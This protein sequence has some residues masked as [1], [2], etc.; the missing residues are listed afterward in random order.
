[1]DFSRRDELGVDGADG[2]G[3]AG[4]IDAEV[5]G[6]EIIRRWGRIGSVKVRRVRARPHKNS[7][8]RL[9]N[10]ALFD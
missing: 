8:N 2:R 1:M 6:L 4:Q 3:C 5:Y 9:D 10:S 7:V